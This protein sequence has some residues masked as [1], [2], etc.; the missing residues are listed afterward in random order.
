MVTLIA[1]AY[2]KCS[3]GPTCL[4]LLLLLF[5]H[6]AMSLNAQEDHLATSPYLVTRFHLPHAIVVGLHVC[7]IT[8]DILTLE[9]A[10]AVGV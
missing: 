7:K 2:V 8:I 10:G 9:T 3:V 6:S 5:R 4:L 1:D